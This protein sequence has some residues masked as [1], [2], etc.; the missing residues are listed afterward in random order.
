MEDTMNT[1][2]LR[3]IINQLLQHSPLTTNIDGS[4]DSNKANTANP[5]KR[6][7]SLFSMKTHQFY[8]HCIASYVAEVLYEE[9]IKKQVFNEWGALLLYDEVRCRDDV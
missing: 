9:C 3:V 6:T 1:H 8:L 5:K 7:L 4:E 2:L